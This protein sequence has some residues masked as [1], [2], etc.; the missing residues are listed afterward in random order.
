MSPASRK[1]ET[2]HFPPPNLPTYS[3]K[4]RFQSTP[5]FFQY[6]RIH[7][8]INLYLLTESGLSTAL[9]QSPAFPDHAHHSH[10]PL[11]LSYSQPKLL[12]ELPAHILLVS[13]LPF[14]SWFHTPQKLPPITPT[15]TKSREHSPSSGYLISQ[16][17]SFF[18]FDTRTSLG[19]SGTL[20]SCFPVSLAYLLLHDLQMTYFKGLRPFLA[21]HTFP[22]HDLMPR[23]KSICPEFMI[24][25][26]TSLTSRPMYLVSYSASPRGCVTQ[27][28]QVEHIQ[29]GIA[30]FH[31][32][33]LF[34]VLVM[35]V[36]LAPD[37]SPRFYLLNV[38]QV[39]PLL[40]TFST[41]NN[42]VLPILPKPHS[43]MSH[44]W[45]AMGHRGIIYTTEIDKH[46]ESALICFAHCRLKKVI[47]K[48]LIM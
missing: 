25:V 43:G 21:R 44:W 14:T 22:L 11:P 9:N 5:H 15:I 3:L 23:F 31:F 1:R 13:Q 47:E 36:P 6:H 33:L 29:K 37:K 30:C 26:L 38:C 39:C 42:V 41:R 27:P 10:A 28:S 18:L 19:D 48:M 40:S 7:S 46:Y 20:P 4:R 12:K 16:R 34:P 45:I 32:L 2:I 17:N 24:L 8:N 35:G